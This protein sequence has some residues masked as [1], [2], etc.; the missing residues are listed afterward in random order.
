MSFRFRQFQVYKEGKIWF[1]DIIL[2]IRDIKQ[3]RYFELS[4]QIERAALSVLLNIAEGSD[5]GSDKEFRRFLDIS[6]GSLNETVAGLD[7]ALDLK[8]ISQANF[9][10]IYLSSENLDKQLGGFRKLLKSCK[11]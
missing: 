9:D 6:L 2:V 10:K 7:V 5:R 11:S 1:Q 8:L 4:N 3:E